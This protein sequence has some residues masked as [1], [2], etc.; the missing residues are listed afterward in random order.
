MVIGE[1]GIVKV[2]DGVVPGFNNRI[3]NMQSAIQGYLNGVIEGQKLMT[4]H[5]ASLQE[6]P[7]PKYLENFEF[8]WRLRSDTYRRLLRLIESLSY[9]LYGRYFTSKL[10]DI[11][12]ELLDEK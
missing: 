4:L 7:V 5:L 10:R 11:N 6:T 2:M 3:N 9:F 1:S 12:L 8:I